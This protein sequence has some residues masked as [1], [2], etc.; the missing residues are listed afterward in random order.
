MRQ[1]PEVRFLQHER[2]EILRRWKAHTMGRVS[3][4]FFQHVV[5]EEG[6]ERVYDEIL[7]AVSS[8]HYRDL[9]QSFDRIVRA[10]SNHRLTLRD[11]KEFLFSFAGVAL[12]ILREKHSEDHNYERLRR[13]LEEIRT[14]IKIVYSERVARGAL[15]VLENHRQT[16]CDL[17]MEELPT[18]VISDH[19]SMIAEEDRRNFIEKTFDIYLHLLRGTEEEE[20]V[21]PEA[22]EVRQTRLAAYIKSVVD[23]YEPKGFLLSDVL[24]ALLHLQHLAEPFLFMALAQE[25]QNYRQARLAL[26]DAAEHLGLEF[27][28]SYNQQMLRNLYSE[29]FIMLHRIKNKLT[30][31][32][33]TMLTVLA[34]DEEGHGREIGAQMEPMVLTVEDAQLIE[35][36]LQRLHKVVE[37]IQQMEAPPPD[38]AAAVRDYEAFMAEHG[39][40]I[41]T[42]H[43]MRLNPTSVAI[44][45]EMLRD[46]VYEG[47]KLTQNL[48]QELQERMREMRDREMPVREE[49]DIYQIARQAYEES[50]A[51]ARS[52]NLE[53]TFE[54]QP[55][56][57]KIL[58]V[59]KDISRP[60]IQLIENAIK[61]TP[62]NGKVHVRLQSEDNQVLFSVQDTGIGI[63]P[64][65]EEYIFELCTRGS[66]AEGANKVG[67]GTGL[68]EDRKTVRHHNGDI[69]VESAGVNQGSTFYIRLPIYRRESTISAD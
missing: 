21:D 31:V 11:A 61:Y 19:F 1:T 48:T 52:K 49:L 60:F 56:G 28:E 9:N 63:V 33:T 16:L 40:Q 38:V 7:S 36:Y 3:S 67:T 17:W 62:E 69:W 59:K 50:I 44:A 51:E 53:Y 68:Y 64:G 12:E 26:E 46:I 8:H 30:S 22:P 14:N 10:D 6:M 27:A 4:S 57:I 20:T 2:S 45:D 39:E 58:G 55:E 35:I 23:F 65:E 13:E 43:M 66:N 24:R 5:T 41:Q 37:T 25:S 34:I 29:V 47:G 15:E 54:G 18:Q 32:P 42:I